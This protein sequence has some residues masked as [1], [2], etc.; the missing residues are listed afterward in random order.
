[1]E[2]INAFDNKHF[3]TLNLALRAEHAARRRK[4]VLSIFYSSIGGCRSHLTPITSGCSNVTSLDVSGSA[5][6]DCTQTISSSYISFILLLVTEFE[7]R[8]SFSV[9]S[10][11]L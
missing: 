10:D 11:R 3:S 9:I 6:C 7:V 1:M 5:T 8:A 4:L 2:L